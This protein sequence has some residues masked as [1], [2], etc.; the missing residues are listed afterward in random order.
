MRI[1]V[2]G[3]FEEKE[4]VRAVQASCRAMGWKITHD[5]THEVGLPAGSTA[6][7]VQRFH[8]RCAL[9]DLRGA[10]SADVVV[11]LLHPAGKGLWV[12]LGAA[13]A[14]G[15]PVIAVG[16]SNCVFLDLP[17]VIRCTKFTPDLV[18]KVVV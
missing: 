8:A 16:D 2:A 6:D 7:E 11:V 5:W 10:I 9:E 17:E 15:V 14:M 13:L 4:A 18:K 3:K 1:Y 12:E